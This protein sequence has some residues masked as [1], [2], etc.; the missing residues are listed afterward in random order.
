MRADGTHK[1]QVTGVTGKYSLEPRFS[2][3]GRFVVYTSSNT[4]SHFGPSDILIARLRDG[5]KVGEIGNDLFQDESP[6]WQ[7]R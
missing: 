7:A 3:D 2:P 6:V 4:R 1:R 5:K